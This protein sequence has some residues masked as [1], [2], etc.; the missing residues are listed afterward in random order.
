M[1]VFS[2]VMNLHSVLVCIYLKG[3]M[4]NLG[5]NEERSNT[6]KHGGSLLKVVF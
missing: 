1:T 4:G 2:S 6:V 3:M 5:K